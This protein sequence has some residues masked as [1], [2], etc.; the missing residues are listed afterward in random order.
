VWALA[1]VF[2]TSSAAPPRFER[3]DN[4]S[5]RD[6]VSGES[7]VTNADG[8]E[9]TTFNG[10]KVPPMTDIEGDKFAETIKDGYW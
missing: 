5:L 9:Y 1:T 7:S 8:V 3:E 6:A 2:A 10:I 4:V